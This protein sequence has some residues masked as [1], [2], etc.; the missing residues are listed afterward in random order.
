MKLEN[1]IFNACIGFS[2]GAIYGFVRNSYVNTD[3]IK[4]LQ[5][6]AISQQEYEKNK[7]QVINTYEKEIPLFPG[8]LGG[9][10]SPVS[11]SILTSSF[12]NMPE[13]AIIG[14]PSAYVGTLFGIGVSKLI[15][16]KNKKIFKEVEKN[17]EKALNYLSSKPISN[18]Q[19]YLIN[20]EQGVLTNN[21][22]A[23]S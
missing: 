4:G 12:N 3:L 6:K 21:K 8:F 11:C 17:P 7:A 23:F 20:L 2:A 22:F 13:K 19:N 5:L 1:I 14:V 18:I 16:Y 10:F 9:I 15:N